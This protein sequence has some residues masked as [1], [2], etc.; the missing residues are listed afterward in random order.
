[1]VW[2]DFYDLEQS[3]EYDVIEYFAGVARIARLS[4]N[5]GYTAGAYDVGYDNPKITEAF[6]GEK[7]NKKK[8]VKGYIAGPKSAM[9]LTTPAGFV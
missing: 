9:D 4:A 6:P 5:F 7:P 1:M 3:K 2:Q 8:K